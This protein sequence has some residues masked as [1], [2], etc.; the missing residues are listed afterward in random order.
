MILKPQQLSVSFL[1]RFKC[2]FKL[3]LQ[4]QPDKDQLPSQGTAGHEARSAWCWPGAVLP[5]PG[6][7]YFPQPVA[8]IDTNS[9]INL[10][11]DAGSSTLNV[12]KYDLSPVVDSP[13]QC[14]ACRISV[15]SK[16]V[17]GGLQVS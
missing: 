10:S 4:D 8:T 14:S 3:A 11:L 1:T 16:S 9:D 17:D 15:K 5:L 12:L 7:G 6:E 13:K 2:N